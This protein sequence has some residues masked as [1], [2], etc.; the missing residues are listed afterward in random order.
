MAEFAAASSEFIDLNILDFVDNIPALEA[1]WLGVDIG[2]SHDR[3]AFATIGLAKGEYY[4]TDIEML[5]GAEYTHQQ[6]RTQALHKEHRYTHGYI[7]ANGI[8]AALSEYVHKSPGCAAIE[9]FITTASNKPKLFE[10]LRSKIFERK[11]HFANKLK[12][13]ILSEFSKISK[14]SNEDGK[15]M[16]LAARDA[17]G[18]CDGTS[19]LI[20]AL[21]AARQ[22]PASATQPSPSPFSSAFGSRFSRL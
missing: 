4:V 10:T 2:S 14:I 1:K 3:T 8:G 19:A 20:L 5:K 13:R 6:A 21:E 16:Y 11:I 18:H 17:D 12:D 15:T 7:D 9:G 22:H